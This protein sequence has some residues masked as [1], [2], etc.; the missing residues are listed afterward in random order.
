[1]GFLDK[2]I[3]QYEVLKRRGVDGKINYRQI[4]G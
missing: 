3:W 1:M 4:F 2:F